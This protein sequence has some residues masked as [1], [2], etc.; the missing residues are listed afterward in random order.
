MFNKKLSSVVW[1]LTLRCNAKCLHCG[2]SAGSK[3]QDELCLADSLKICE[4]LA[5]LKCERVNLIGG[6]AFLNPHWKSIAKKLSADGIKVSVI[7]NA[8][9]LTKENL[10]FLK[11]INIETLGISIDG[12]TAKTHD[13]IRQVPGLFDKIF[14]L[15][16]YVEKLKIPSAAVTTLNKINLA[17]MPLLRDKLLTS[18]FKGWQFQV[19][20][21]YGRMK[22]S[23]LLD[24]EEFYIA[25]MFCMQMKKNLAGK[26]QINTMHDFGYY[27]KIIKLR[28]GIFEWGGC[29]AG[30]RTIGIRSDGKV[31]GCLSMYSEEFAEGD[32]TKNSLKE[33]FYSK[34]FCR[35]NKRF[36]KYKSLGGYCK[37]CEYGLICLAGC[38]D[39]AHGISG[40]VGDNPFCYHAIEEYYR[41][42]AP[43]DDFEKLFKEITAGRITT[44]RAEDV[45]KSNI[46]QNKK[47]ILKIICN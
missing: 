13:H 41:T 46:P 5:E 20:V 16:A 39:T 38:S 28:E 30:K 45:E 23:L 6:E 22:E 3:R 10:D 19:A 17:E 7:T 25:G 21:P 47:D 43:K 27:S 35:W 42:L 11:E 14:D 37:E 32:L 40:S 26:I 24:R 2:S 36:S 29:P 18:P 1:E 33:I 34:D 12:G 15:M 4:Q 31:H 9:L 8:I 44:L